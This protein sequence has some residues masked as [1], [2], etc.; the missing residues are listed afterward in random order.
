MKG[1]CGSEKRREKY[2]EEEKKEDGGKRMGT[3]KTGGTMGKGRR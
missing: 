3:T 1:E 2:I